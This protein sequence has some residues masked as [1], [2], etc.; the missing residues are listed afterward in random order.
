MN[1]KYLIYVTYDIKIGD[2]NII[3]YIS[4]N[5]DVFHTMGEIMFRSLYKINR[6]TFVD[7]KES[8]IKWIK[9]NNIPLNVF[10]EKY[11]GGYNN[12]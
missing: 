8:S 3:A 12:G 2:S 6:I 11:I 10:K 5:K 9:E 1:N 7:Y 4:T